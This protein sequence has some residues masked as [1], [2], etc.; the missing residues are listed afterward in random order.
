[1][2]EPLDVQQAEFDRRAHSGI[3]PLI[4][5]YRIPIRIFQLFVALALIH[6]HRELFDAYRSLLLGVQE[7]LNAALG[8]RKLTLAGVGQVH[9]ALEERHALLQAKVAMF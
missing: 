9:S 2:P 5:S 6:C 8:R 4:L 1:M 7:H 3:L